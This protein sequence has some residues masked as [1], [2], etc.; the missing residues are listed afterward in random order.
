VC[1]VESF[2]WHSEIKGNFGSGVVVQMCSPCH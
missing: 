1:A 2:V